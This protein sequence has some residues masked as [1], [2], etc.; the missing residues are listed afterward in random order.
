MARP[1]TLNENQVVSTR[2][3]KTMYQTLHDLASLES[4]N[5]GKVVTVQEL[6]RNALSYVYSD[7]EHLRESFRRSRAHIA[8]RY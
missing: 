8:K 7:N 3:E 1:T 2:I 4:L 5:S 6:I